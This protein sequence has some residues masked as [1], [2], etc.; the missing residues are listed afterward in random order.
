MWALRYL[1]LD[2]KA[3]ERAIK[4]TYAKM[5]KQT[6]PDDDPEGF[7]RLHEAYQVALEWYRTQQDEIL[8]SYPD[9]AIANHHDNEDANSITASPNW[10]WSFTAT[11]E[12]LETDNN[13]YKQTD[14]FQWHKHFTE[15]SFEADNNLHDQAD[16]FQWH[17]HFTEAS[18]TTALNEESL[19]AFDL[20]Y[21]EC[22]DIGRRETSEKLLAYLN[23]YPEL[24]DFEIKNQIGTFLFERLYQ[25]EPSLRLACFDVLCDFFN[26]HDISSAIDYVKL[27][28][29]RQCTRIVRAF[30]QERSLSQQPVPDDEDAILP[31]SLIRQLH[32][33]FSWPQFL[34]ASIF[35]WRAYSWSAKLRELFGDSTEIPTTQ[36]DP[37]QIQHWLGLKQKG[38]NATKLLVYTLW[39]VCCMLFVRT[40][41]WLISSLEKFVG[42]TG[43]IS[44][45][46][47]EFTLKLFFALGM[48]IIVYLLVYLLCLVLKRYIFWQHLI[49]KIKTRQLSLIWLLITIGVI[50][51]SFDIYKA[52]ATLKLFHI[53][54]AITIACLGLLMLLGYG[55]WQSRPDN[56]FSEGYFK[57]LTQFWV[58]LLCIASLAVSVIDLT[59]SVPIV[60]LASI[61]SGLRLLL[62]VQAPIF[63]QN[64][65]V[66]ILFFIITVTFYFS[67]STLHVN[68]TTI[69]LGIILPLLCWGYDYYASLSAQIDHYTPLKIKL[70]IY[71]RRPFTQRFF[72]LLL[73][74]AWIWVVF[75]ALMYVSGKPAS[76][77]L[78]IL[79]YIDGHTAEVALT[80]FYDLNII[81]IAT[82]GSLAF[83]GYAFWQS[84]PDEFFNKLYFKLL[85]Q[86]WIPFLC[87]LSIIISTVNLWTAKWIALLALIT[88][89]LRFLLRNLSSLF[90]FDTLLIFI[91]VGIG[92]IFTTLEFEE[93]TAFV[94]WYNLIPSLSLWGYNYYRQFKF[95]KK[96]DHRLDSM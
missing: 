79:P 81:L 24:W 60:L 43:S 88:S 83:M 23:H 59:M 68:N 40:G 2:R 64:L 27:I 6:R 58:P 76:T 21:A 57:L 25:E 41:M 74:D 28:K 62:R 70:L 44:E 16:S 47:A 45:L 10:S 87:F 22:I 7:Q 5:L 4:R 42:S 65:Y 72:G 77:I 84:R 20:F 49:N 51:K 67:L 36:C 3:D 56:S 54:D 75:V 69:R 38:I 71:M 31:D 78:Q 37:N 55:F 52:G 93:D 14:S 53:L 9:E 94:L 82:L 66:W 50:H 90:M 11:P 95:I 1:H 73:L 33:P 13:L 86:F 34:I 48:I 29:L 30:D 15:E 17:P 19:A 35:P 32:R 91:F 8:S 80:L 46:I 96:Q 39:V 18:F 89:G 85:A 12:S 92:I 26:W 61:T 63:R